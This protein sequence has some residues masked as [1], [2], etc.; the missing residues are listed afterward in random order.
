MTGAWG[1]IAHIVATSTGDWRIAYG[2][3]II[4]K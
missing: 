3:I 2:V 1:I 4:N